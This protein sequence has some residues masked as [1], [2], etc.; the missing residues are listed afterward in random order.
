MLKY[1]LSATC[2]FIFSAGLLK[3]QSP[4]GIS[5]NNKIWLR[6]DNGITAAG[7]T[8]TQWQENSGAGVTGNFTVQAL[9]GTANVQTGPTLIPAGVNFNPY[10]SFDGI[11]NSL[12]S[13]NNFVGTA[14]VGNSNVTVFQ[15]INLK[16]GV[17]WLKW[18]TDQL[19]TTARLGFENAAGRLRF[20][21]PRANPPANG[22]NIGVT[23]ILNKHTLSTSFVNVNTSVNRLGGADDNTIPIPGPGNFGAANT[24]IVIGNENLLNLPCR[25]DMAEVI[26][27]SNTLTAAERNKIE[28]YLAVKYGFTLNQ[29]AA[30]NN[31]YVATNAAITWDRALNSAYAN[32]ITG[33]G[34]DDAT[35]LNQKQ[36]RSV[37][38]TSLVTL[39]NGSYAAGVFPTENA[40]NSNSFSNDLSFLLVG[41]NGGTTTVDQCALDG[42]AHRMQRIW[43]AS[44][45]GPVSPV[46]IAVDQASVPATVKN[47][48]VSAN[49][50]FPLSAT[51]I[52]SVTAAGG[53]LYSAVT[54]SH[55]DYFTFSSDTIPLPQLQAADVCV[56]TNGTA[57]VMN[58]V[59]GA[60][61]NWYNLSA[62]GILVGTG[63]S[64][65][66]PNLPNDTTLYV[67]T[68]SAF[69]CV[70]PV[71]VPVTIKVQTVAT[72]QANALQTTCTVNTGSITITSPIGPGY[73]YCINGAGCQAG[74]T[75]SN[76]L[77]GTYS[78]T[79]INAL[80]C[81]SQVLPVTINAQ[82]AVPAAPAVNAPVTICENQT[83]TLSITS[84]VAG[85]TY[86]WY[87]S[88]TAVTP[89]HTGTTFT[90]PVLFVPTIYYAEAVNAQGCASARTNAE[91]LIRTQLASPLVSVVQVTDSSILFSWAAVPGA[92]NYSV[93]TNGINYTLPSSG[94]NGT[95]HLVTG[96]LPRATLTL[97]V[98]AL[99]TLTPCI[100]SKNGTA[101]GT[102]LAKYDDVYVPSA[103]TPNG[104]LL[105]NT[106]RVYGD[107]K[108]YRFIVYNRYGQLVFSTTALNAGWDGT[109]KGKAQ[110]TGTYAWYVTATLSDGRTVN[111]S[112][113][114]I[115]LR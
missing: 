26:I 107:I 115:L 46:T 89:V 61:Y 54:I 74:L 78:I 36:S 16:S 85:N 25:I 8:V 39:Y 14:L 94:I 66:I 42:N 101:T 23:N 92:N 52:Y 91:V 3:A 67:E 59:P 82:P 15:V 33:I 62:G 63:T 18:E 41:D 21:F 76:L 32:D 45:T 88:P 64:I 86:N 103:F 57:V 49:P 2:C 84:P 28:S 19:G 43:K 22:Q 75:F 7:S 12:S 56:N 4:G 35:A 38:T 73:Q 110:S 40:S 51:T 113:T 48:L 96:L 79:A 65:T 90:T 5:A 34:R 108:T 104:D 13:V 114:S 81:I 9:A 112:G 20:D 50:A 70:L 100:A 11:T 71:R 95:T 10:L 58:P 44:N 37:N 29:L 99:D 6:S 27:Y 77:P 97:Y 83:A 109:F 111:L 98:K 31:N 87:T 72:P 80:G 69:G 1:L 17:V 102:T 93:S 55:N 24:K 105:N 68:T 30:N 53:K 60:V 106:L 47:I